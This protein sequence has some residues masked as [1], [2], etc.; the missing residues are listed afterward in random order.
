MYQIRYSFP[1]YIYFLY[2]LISGDQNSICSTVFS[3]SAERTEL[4][5]ETWTLIHYVSSCSFINLMCQEFNFAG[6]KSL[7]LGLSPFMPQSTGRPIY[8][9]YVQHQ[10]SLFALQHS[11]I[12]SIAREDNKSHSQ[13]MDYTKCAVVLQA[14][15]CCGLVCKYYNIST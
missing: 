5:N 7:V 4:T 14:S 12:H 9:F 15:V 8:L 2:Y 13:H 6:R 11:E 10:T 1:F 3:I